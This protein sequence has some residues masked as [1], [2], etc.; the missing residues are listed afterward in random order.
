M[1]SSN[2]PTG[3]VAG[4]DS[5]DALGRPRPRHVYAGATRFPA[6]L[7]AE[8]LSSPPD[9]S[10]RVSRYHAN[11]TAPPRFQQPA[12][13]VSASRLSFLVP[14]SAR[15]SLR[16][17]GPPSVNRLFYTD[18]RALLNGTSVPAKNSRSDSFEPSMRWSHWIIDFLLAAS[19]PHMRPAHPPHRA[20]FTRS[21]LLGYYCPLINAIFFSISGKS[22]VD[23][24]PV[25][26]DPLVHQL[27]AVDE[28]KVTVQQVFPAVVGRERDVDPLVEVRVV[29]DDDETLESAAF[30]LPPA[31]ID[32]YVLIRKGALSVRMVGR[33]RKEV[34][35]AQRRIPLADV[36]QALVQPK[37][38]LADAV[39]A[40]RTVALPAQRPRHHP[41]W[42]TARQDL[43]LA[44]LRTVMQ[45]HRSRRGQ[46]RKRRRLGFEPAV[47]P[48]DLVHKR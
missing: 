6:R 19:T 47:T 21:H 35:R 48:A 31:V 39:I 37:Q 32:D 5:P 26:V 36:N 9:S 3:F 25:G 11:F 17:A 42:T 8:R 10:L 33:I 15:L 27:M 2:P 45:H 41:T 30:G 12:R 16:P 18:Y 38:T 28:D 46:E 23:P 4:A 24:S 20:L 13:N 29:D 7:T 40:E 1:M 14:P 44:E 43:L 22:V 34:R